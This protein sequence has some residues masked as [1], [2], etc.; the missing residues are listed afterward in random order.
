MKA[1]CIVIFVV[2]AMLFPAIHAKAQQNDKKWHFLVEPYLMFPNMNGTTGVGTQSDVSVNENPGDI[3]SNLQI[4]AMLYAEASRGRWAV[5]SDLTYMKLGSDISS[6]DGS[7]T[8]NADE[9]QLAWELAI[10]RRFLP[11]LEAGVGAQLNSIKT[12]IDLTEITDAGPEAFNGDLTKT[13]VDPSIIVR[14]KF[15]LSQRWFIQGRGNIGG[16][17]AGSRLYW[18]A[19]AYVGYHISKVFQVSVGYRAIG[20]DYNKGSGDNRFLYDITTFGPVARFGI[21]F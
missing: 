8:G 20:V 7:V 13:W 18:Q 16:F 12:T 17:D 4:G 14:V 21:N 6:S 19:Q 5:T 11:W 9:K 2:A 3:F 1:N 15:P 10:L